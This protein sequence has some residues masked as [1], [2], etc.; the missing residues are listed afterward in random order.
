[1]NLKEKFNEL[2]NYDKYYKMSEDELI[3][4]AEKNH[5]NV[6]SDGYGAGRRDLILKQLIAKDNTAMFK[7]SLIVSFITLIC[8]MIS[9][10]VS[11]IAIFIK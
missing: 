6:Y 2:F 10:I 8:V 7:R 1:M 3:K 11:I 5:L 9:L 4:K